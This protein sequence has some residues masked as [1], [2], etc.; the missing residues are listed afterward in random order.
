MGESGKTTARCT[1]SVETGQCTWRHL[2]VLLS[3][4]TTSSNVQ[5]PHQGGNVW[6]VSTHTRTWTGVSCEHCS[7]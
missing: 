4:Q 1:V 3:D 5:T 7:S 6:S 2:D